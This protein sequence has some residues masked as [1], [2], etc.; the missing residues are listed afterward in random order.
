MG[1]TFDG[2]QKFFGGKEKLF[3]MEWNKL[4]RIGKIIEGVENE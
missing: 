4:K 1:D 2:N 3:I